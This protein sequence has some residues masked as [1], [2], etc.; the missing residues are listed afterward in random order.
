[1]N[2]AIFVIAGID[3]NISPFLGIGQD[4]K[5][6]SPTPGSEWRLWR[7]EAFITPSFFNEASSRP[8][9]S[10]FAQCSICNRTLGGG[11]LFG[12]ATRAGHKRPSATTQEAA[13]I[14]FSP[15]PRSSVLNF[16]LSIDKRHAALA[17][18]IAARGPRTGAPSHRSFWDG[19]KT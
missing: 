9:L 10:V 1:M 3:Q 7:H 15:R 14:C 4:N 8:N 16:L 11:S 6:S 2:S 5:Y 12:A 17:P 18:Q 13:L 19:Y